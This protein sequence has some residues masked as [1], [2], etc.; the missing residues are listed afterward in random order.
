[1]PDLKRV[2]KADAAILSDI[3]VLSP[4]ISAFAWDLNDPKVTVTQSL[5]DSE[6]AKLGAYFGSEDYKEW[7]SL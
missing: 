6:K 3:Q 5:S 7:I 1:M 2:N 4:K